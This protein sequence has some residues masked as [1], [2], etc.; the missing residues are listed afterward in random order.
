MSNTWKQQE[1][2]PKEFKPGQ[3][4]LVKKTNDGRLKLFK[5]SEA[6]A[7]KLESFRYTSPGSISSYFDAVFKAESEDV[8]SHDV[9]LRKF[10]SALNRTQ[11]LYCE[12][13]G[14]YSVEME[15]PNGK[16]YR[17][18]YACVCPNALGQAGSVMDLV[19]QRLVTLSCQL[20]GE[21]GECCPLVAKQD[22]CRGFQCPKFGG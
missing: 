6:T 14:Y 19:H 4:A 15:A 17:L 2:K 7:D 20:G 21:T 16:A 9:Q 3:V 1:A 13:K 22:K 8:S 18:S 5:G 11:C 10:M 12:D